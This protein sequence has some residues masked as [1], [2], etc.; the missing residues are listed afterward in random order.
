MGILEKI[1]SPDSIKSLT[2]DSLVVLAEEIRQFL[3]ENVSKT[4]GHL[5]SNLGVV[6]LTLGIHKVFNS[7]DDSIIFDVGHQ[8]YVHKIL[9]GRK[10]MFSSLRKFGGLSGFPKMS[11]SVHDKFNSGHASNSISVA[12]G[13]AEANRLKGNK[14]YS[15]AILGD[16]ALTGGLAFEALNN[17][18]RLKSNLVVI[19]ND[20][21]MSISSNVGSLTNYLNKLR[22][23][24]KYT[25]LKVKVKETLDKSA[26]GKKFSHILSNTKTGIK[27]ML[28][29]GTIFEA[30][31]F[32]YIGPIDG[33]DISSVCSALESAKHMEKPVFIHAYTKKG[34]GYSFAEEAPHL[35]H[36][37]SSFDKTK[38]FEPKNS[39]SYSKVCGDAILKYAGNDEKI[40]AICAAM[41]DSTGLTPFS[42]EFPDRFF[43]VGISEGHA[44]TFAA[45]L[46]KNGFFPAICIYSTFMQRAYDN[47]V[48]DLALQGFPALLC[49]D[50]AGLVGEDGETHHGIFDVSYLSHIPNLELFTP[51]SKEGLEAALKYVFEN[52][53]KLYA[54]RY[55]RGNAVETETEITDIFV[56]EKLRCGEDVTVVSISSMTNVVKKAEFCGDHFHLNCIKPLNINEIAESL[57]KTGKLVTVEDNLVSGGMGQLLSKELNEN[58]IS[59]FSHL[60]IGI[61]DRFVPQG[62]V[63]QLLEFLEMD[64]ISLSKRIKEFVK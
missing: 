21:E 2:N 44:V 45:G 18:G 55:P 17:A 8:S 61:E 27:H 64:E 29:S 49:L 52:K 58:S 43:D 35:Y 28:L 30:L 39:L 53:D 59:D 63:A 50:R 41:R 19:L 60:P 3:I 22:T 14:N 32:T 7:P 31:G 25:D 1:T 46:S 4:G 16:G 13:I 10:D 15:V 24:E 12:A 26:I 20:N 23:T 11:E 56:P 54:V 62:S 51:Y 57:K 47:I 33:H 42:A 36:G 48:H 40:V 38:P 6:E 5:A 9:T 34:K 37:I